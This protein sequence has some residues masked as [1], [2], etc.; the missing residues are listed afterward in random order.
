MR[1]REA[2]ERLPRKKPGSGK[3][4]VPKNRQLPACFLHYKVN[5]TVSLLSELERWEGQVPCS[6]HL[7]I[8]ECLEGL[9]VGDWCEK[10]SWEP[11]LRTGILLLDPQKLFGMFIESMKEGMR[12]GFIPQKNDKCGL[13]VSTPAA[14]IFAQTKVIS[15][16]LL[17]FL[18]LIVRTRQTLD[19]EPPESSQLLTH[20][21]SNAHSLLSEPH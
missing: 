7:P 5:K 17:P 6:L 4:P 21:A 8:I 16:S 19:I 11:E 2:A 14:F 3:A 12:L 9:R 18:L 13:L 1:G 15:S 20:P 10:L